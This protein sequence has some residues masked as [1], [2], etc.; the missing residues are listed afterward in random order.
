[1]AVVANSLTFD[2]HARKVTIVGNCNIINYA[3]PDEGEIVIVG[4]QNEINGCA[5]DKVTL[6]GDDNVI[7][8]TVRLVLVCGN[9][10]STL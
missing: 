7:A 9:D 3:G 2:A 10:N 5:L 8:T 4:N 6:I 1:M